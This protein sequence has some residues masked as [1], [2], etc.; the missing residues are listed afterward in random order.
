M[1]IACALSLSLCMFG[2][3]K[4]L[5]TIGKVSYVVYLDL[6]RSFY[7]PVTPRFRC[8]SFSLRLYVFLLLLLLLPFVDREPHSINTNTNSKCVRSFRLYYWYALF[9]TSL[10][11]FLF[12]LT[13]IVSF[14]IGSVNRLLLLWIWLLNIFYLYSWM[15][16]L[17]A[18][19]LSTRS[20]QYQSVIE[21]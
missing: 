11:V 8:C 5:T 12:I 4:W 18:V 13:W 20:R 9:F 3:C 1:L 10:R 14:H 17:A 7:S 16:V 6:F 21:K 2:S 19:Q 15:I